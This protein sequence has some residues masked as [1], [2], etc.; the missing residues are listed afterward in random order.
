MI[1]AGIDEAGY[2][3]LLG[4]LVV[5]ACAFELP[6]DADTTCLWTRLRKTVSKT[7]CRQH[8]KLHFNDSKL[9]YASSNGLK[10]LEQSVLALSA[11][12]H[13]WPGDLDGL[14]SAVAAH[15]LPELAEHP[16]YGSVEGEA[17]PLETSSVAIQMFANSLSAEMERTQTRC[18]HWSA[19]VV[20][21]RPFNRMCQATR[22]K[23]NTLF[24]IAAIHLDALLRTFGRRG[25][26][27]RCDRQGGRSHYGYLLRQMFEDWSLEIVN[28]SDARSDY[29][30][31][32]AGHTVDIIFMEKAEQACMT[33][34]AAS[35]LCKYLRQALMSRFNHWWAGHVPG[36]APTAGYHGDAQRFLADIAAARTTLKIDDGDLLRCR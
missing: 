1:V 20:S 33:V 31:H 29:R 28:E 35:M 4:P 30:L 19:R 32:Q 14:L 22:N 7:R 6:D 24:S 9:V 26:T 8:R 21:E 5:G 17:F 27:I 10:E 16:W 34:A 11:A 15:A 23:S 18:V 12:V 25:L 13:G 36:L 2:G 3:P